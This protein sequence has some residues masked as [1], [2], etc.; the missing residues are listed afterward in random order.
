M[1]GVLYNGYETLMFKNNV[2]VSDGPNELQEKTYYISLFT[3]VK[4]D[5]EK[6]YLLTAKINNCLHTEFERIKSWR[7]L[8]CFGIAESLEEST[9]A[10]FGVILLRS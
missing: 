1:V 10:S 7:N 9:R 4:I 6:I 2:L 5:K 8:P 3:D